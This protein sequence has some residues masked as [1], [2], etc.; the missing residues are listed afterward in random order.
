ME[1]NFHAVNVNKNLESPSRGEV[2][3]EYFAVNKDENY[4]SAELNLSN[5]AI[6]TIQQS[7]VNIE[8]STNDKVVAINFPS[9]RSGNLFFKS[10]GLSSSIFFE[11]LYYS[12][13]LV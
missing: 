2:K 10:F 11:G 6:G 3:F 1:H 8:E 7:S 5:G 12:N 13:F 9:K 4:D